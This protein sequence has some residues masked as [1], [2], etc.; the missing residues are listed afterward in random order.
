MRRTI[1]I[2][3]ITYLAEGALRGAGSLPEAP[4]NQAFARPLAQALGRPRWAAARFS[5]SARRCEISAVRRCN[6]NLRCTGRRP[7]RIIASA[8]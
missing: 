7:S 4:L 5:G 6:I 1:H 8:G 2:L 3:K